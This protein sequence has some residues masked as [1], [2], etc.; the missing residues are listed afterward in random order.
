MITPLG[1]VK[2]IMDMLVWIVEIQGI[3]ITNLLRKSSL[4]DRMFFFS[5]FVPCSN[6]VFL[7]G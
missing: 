7:V 2:K 6:E 5:P 3:K 1:S 4:E